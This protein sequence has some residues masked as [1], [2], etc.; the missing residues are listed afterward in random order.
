[1][2]KKP[3]TTVQH[4]WNDKKS[5]HARYLHCAPIRCTR[6]LER[7]HKNTQSL[8]STIK[9]SN[10]DKF[11]AQ[12]KNVTKTPRSLLDDLGYW[13]IWKTINADI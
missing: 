2:I 13:T 9:N 6:L 5:S 11:T 10:C 8:S 12:D 3:K 4:E 1:M 7:D